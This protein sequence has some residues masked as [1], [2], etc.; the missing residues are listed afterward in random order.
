MSQIQSHAKPSIKKSSAKEWVS[1]FTE[2]PEERWPWMPI[3]KYLDDDGDQLS[4]YVEGFLRWRKNVFTD[5]AL[6]D[7]LPS[8][9]R[10][11]C[12]YAADF[13]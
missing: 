10:A 12:M 9:K 5:E 4:F 2:F 13:F 11:H 3:D 7:N 1:F 8:M 6:L